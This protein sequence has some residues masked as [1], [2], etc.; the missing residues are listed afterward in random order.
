MMT[1][2]AF[3]FF[4]VGKLGKWW[5][6]QKR[7]LA[8]LFGRVLFFFLKKKKEIEKNQHTSLYSLV[9]FGTRVSRICKSCRL[10]NL[11]FASDLPCFSVVVVVKVV[12]VV[13]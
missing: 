8:C 11:A 3:F 13:V 7:I 5:Y 6:V 9:T 2:F 1:F 10:R 4:F 12:L